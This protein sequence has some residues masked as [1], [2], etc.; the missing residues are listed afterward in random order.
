MGNFKVLAAVAA[1][2]LIGGAAAAKEKPDQPKVK[3][4]CRTEQMS[5]RITPTRV[6]RPKDVRPAGEQE[7]QREARS[8]DEP[9]A[10]GN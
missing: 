6:C 4:V 2:L 1:A 5:G 10:R 3:K 7:S 9:P 8:S